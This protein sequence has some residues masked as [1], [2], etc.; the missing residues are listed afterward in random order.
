MTTKCTDIISVLPSYPER[1][2]SKLRT[3]DGNMLTDGR[4][5]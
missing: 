1:M 2:A 3:T 4:R 5:F